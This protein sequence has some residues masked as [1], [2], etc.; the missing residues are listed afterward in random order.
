MKTRGERE[1]GSLLQAQCRDQCILDAI[2]WSQLEEGS[3]EGNLT[4]LRDGLEG[5][6]NMDQLGKHLVVQGLISEAEI[7]LE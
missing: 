3:T 2:K 5:K 4:G 1:G 6:E 7:Q